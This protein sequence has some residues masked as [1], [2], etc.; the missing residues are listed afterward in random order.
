MNSKF[1]HREDVPKKKKVYL[2]PQLSVVRIELESS[3]AAG[4]IGNLKPGTSSGDVEV[5]DWLER[6]VIVDHTF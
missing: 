4:S 2:P 1:E 5:V 3:I 6:E